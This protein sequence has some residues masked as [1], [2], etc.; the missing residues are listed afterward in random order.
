MENRGVVIPVNYYS[1]RKNEKF[2]VYGA[3][4]QGR[5]ICDNLLNSGFDVLAFIDKSHF[6]TPYYRGVPI[7]DYEE[8]DK[9]ACADVVI[10][11]SLINPFSHEDVA[12]E[13]LKKGFKRIVCKRRVLQQERNLHVNA[14][15]DLLTTYHSEG[16][17]RDIVGSKYEKLESDVDQVADHAFIHREYG[18]V[19]AYLPIELIY[20]VGKPV[21]MQTQV[22]RM[23]EQFKG[24]DNA[25]MEKFLQYVYKVQSSIQKDNL[26]QERARIIKG[27]IK[28]YK[29]MVKALSLDRDFFV[30]HPVTVTYKKPYFE[31]ADGMHRALFL[32]VNGVRYVPCSI[33]EKEYD[34]WMADTTDAAKE[35]QPSNIPILHPYFY[36]N[37]TETEDVYMSRID[38]VFEFMAERGH[39][40]MS[41]LDYGKNDAWTAR[42]LARAGFKVLCCADA[43][44]V[45]RIDKYSRVEQLEIKT[46]DSVPN[47]IFDITVSI[48]LQSYLPA[49]T[50]KIRNIIEHTRKYGF[51][52]VEEPTCMEQFDVNYNVL[53]LSN[54]PNN[55]FKKLYLIALEMLEQ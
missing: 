2:C 19:T 10:V 28:V 25:G 39:E 9:F 4:L 54:N 11:I 3:G 35:A 13:L 29:N 38:A 43:D 18:Y 36:L 51:F 17:T 34:Q 5:C 41:V 12:N 53:M 52:E 48:D 16:L 23:F 1:I 6:Q 40:E 44:E 15:Y 24:I 45:S 47:S 27:R 55:P 7:V 30:R 22:I 8:A 33:P 32:Y 14:L 46:V 49:D 37:Q 21:I 42:N 31:I 26:D 50:D 20:A